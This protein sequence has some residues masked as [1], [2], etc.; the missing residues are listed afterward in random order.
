MTAKLFGKLPDGSEVHEVT[1]AAGKLAV[2]IIT[3]GAIVRDLRLDGVD[4]PL[5]LGFE[6]LDPYLR[7]SPYFGAIVGRSANR[8]GSG[9]I[10]IGGKSYQ[11]PLNDHGKHHLHGGPN[12][13][14]ARLWRLV[15]SGASSLTLSLV[16][17]DGEEGYPGRTEAV[18]RYRIDPPATLGLEMEAT[19]DAPTIAN[20]AQHAYFNLDDSPD[21]LDH[22]LEIAAEAYTPVDDDKIPTGEIVPVTGTD[23]DF[24]KS[25]PIRLL[26]DRRRVAYDVNF[27]VGRERSAEPHLH[28]RLMSPKN[29]VALAVSS[30]EPG[31]QF[32]DGSMMKVPVP[33]LGGRRYGV[34]SG[35][36]LESQLF[37]DAPNHARFP[38]SLLRPGETYR[39][40]TRL[41]F[42]RR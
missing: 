21:I 34:N 28:A 36:C 3:L 7:H 16:S 41:A 4:H 11:L 19:T 20:L 13:F 42:S 27:V 24:R 30:T 35:C 40:I 26:R 32:Y 18:V 12:G 29:G 31:V 15:D 39:Q 5:V 17:P 22:R 1:I 2:S 38:S 25:R 6:T 9:R 10:A 14:S 23:F 33:G 8:I 37:P